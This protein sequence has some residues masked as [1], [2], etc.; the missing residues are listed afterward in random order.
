VCTSVYT[1]G[2]KVMKRYLDRLNEYMERKGYQSIEEFSG[3][4]CSRI[5][6]ADRVDRRKLAVALIDEERCSECAICARVCLYGAVDRGEGTYRINA[7]C[8]GCGLC[9]ELCPDGAITMTAAA[10]A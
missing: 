3:R 9:R 1:E 6:P 7:A 5:I 10:G 4:V 2:F 8:A